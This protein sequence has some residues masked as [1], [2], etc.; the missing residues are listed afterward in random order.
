LRLTQSGNPLNDFT[1]LEIDNADSV[2]AELG[3]EE[4]LPRQ[5]NRQVIDSTAHFAERDLGFQLQGR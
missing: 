1:R 2:I 5:V 3:D 4:S